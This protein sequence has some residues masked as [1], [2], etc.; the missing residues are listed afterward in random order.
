MGAN[1]GGAHIL[2]GGRQ[3]CSPGSQQRG[4]G[5]RSIASNGGG[6]G[7]GAAAERGRSAAAVALAA[8]AGLSMG[9]PP[10]VHPESGVAVAGLLV[11]GLLAHT[12]APGAA[13]RLRLAAVC[14]GLGLAGFNLA[15]SVAPGTSLGWLA[16]LALPAAAFALACQLPRSGRRG[17]LAVIVASGALVAVYG[18][19]QAFVGLE[20]TAERARELGV[21]AEAVARLEQ[22][23]AFATHALPASLAGAL[24]VALA[25]A[26]A[27]ALGARGRQ[28]RWAA[29]AA[30]AV[31]A[32][33]LLATGSVGAWIGLA[34]GA[35][36]V[37]RQLRSGSALRL[38]GVAAAALVTLVALAAIKP[39]SVLDL[40]NPNH[41]LK[42]RLDNWVGAVRIAG[43]QPVA[44]TGLGSFGSLYPGVRQPDDNETLY[45][46]NSWLQLAVEGGLPALVLLVAAAWA[47]WRRARDDLE[48]ERLWALAGAVAFAAHNLVD[49]TAF[50]PGVAVPAM[51]MAGIAFARGEAPANVSRL[52]DR[53]APNGRAGASAASALLAVT[54]AGAAALFALE[55]SARQGLADAGAASREGRRL[56]AA[57]AGAS[58]AARAPWLRSV[59]VRAGN[60]LLDGG[61]RHRRRAAALARDLIRL[62]PASPSP[63]HLLANAE[64]VRGRPANAWRALQHARDRH[65]ADRD[66][67]ARSARVEQALRGA[68]LLDAG[69]DYGSRTASEPPGLQARWEDVL[70]LV[71]LGMAALVAWRW[72]RPGPAPAAAFAVALALL[73]AGFGEG[74][75]LAG[76]RLGWILLVVLGLL[77]CREI[78]LRLPAALGPA[79]VLAAV[80]AGLAPA[81]AAARDGLIALL[82]VL[83]VV[84]LSAEL[85]RSRDGWLDL[86]ISVLGAVAALQLAL[87]AV[88]RAGAWLGFE[89]AAWP[90][91]FRS[92]HPVRPDGDFLHPGHLGSFLVAVGLALIA[93]SWAR[94]PGLRAP[95]ILGAVMVAAGMGQAA[96]ASL[97]A[98]A[99][100]GAVLV[101]VALRGRARFGFGIALAA[102]GAVGGGFAVSRIAADP[103]AWSRLKIWRGALE[104]FLDRPWLGF[105]PGG[106]DPFGSRYALP[107]PGPVARFAK[108]FHQPHSDPLDALVSLGLLGA[109]ALGAGL[110]WLGVRAGRTDRHAESIP[111]QRVAAWIALAAL[112]AHGLVDGFLGQRPVVALA[113]AALFGGLAGPSLRRSAPVWRPTGLPRALAAAGVVTALVSGEALPWL[114]YRLDAEGAPRAA[115]LVDPLRPRFHVAAAGPAGSADTA[116]GSGG[117]EEE[118]ARALVRVERAVLAAPALESPWAERARLLEAACRG[119]LPERDTCA[120]ALA[121]WSA[122]IARDPH[123]VFARRARG[124]LHRAL[125]DEAAARTDL[126]LALSIEPTFLGARID[127]ARLQLERGELAAA[128]AELQELRARA[129]EVDGVRSGSARARELLRVDP[130]AVRELS[131]GLSAGAGGEAAP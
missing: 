82:A 109:V 68:G 52:Q 63:W 98:L 38:A 42:R 129:A 1:A 116:G 17:V 23:R 121:S 7:D 77:A 35:A 65:P 84:L 112:A 44:G 56:E 101:L 86:V 12:R 76:A 58:A 83:A 28:V 55:A 91:P 94:R 51:A 11:L 5:L 117:P 103:Y 107:D 18:L 110:A 15:I 128:R 14:V 61:P 113:A 130:E 85:G 104:A 106:L 87:L 25:A 125:G 111:P 126:R 69:L 90:E 62:D 20:Q 32:A 21:S 66:L 36:V 95:L 37:F 33:G 4:I 29:A 16:R 89:P 79:A 74:G 67:Q 34:A 2:P 50:L 114:A 115:A 119:P 71:A 64:A 72:W 48:P 45:A 24:T 105:G 13:P 59:Q 81:P 49:F 60:L 99:A 118:L 100:G 70:L 131:R 54:L 75:A 123:D 120:A 122:V 22:G 88:Q 78:D 97:L 30:A 73:L 6:T 92:A 43:A 3:L 53:T 39:A 19:F 8:A 93:R 47:L 108:V 57:D 27:V 10:E 40:D 26:G 102:A 124:R 127:L 96:R 31:A 9:L 41:P 80:S 46:H